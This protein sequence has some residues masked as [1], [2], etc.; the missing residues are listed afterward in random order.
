MATRNM[1]NGLISGVGCIGVHAHVGNDFIKV[2]YS[3]SYRLVAFIAN[4]GGGLYN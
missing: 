4:S 3:R 2:E 1:F